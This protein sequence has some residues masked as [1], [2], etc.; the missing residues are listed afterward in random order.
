MTSEARALDYEKVRS[1]L[2][3]AVDD[4]GTAT[5]G[6]LSFIGERLKLFKALAAAG[7]VTIEE[8]AAKTRLNARY[9]REW[10]NAMTAARYVIHDSQTRRYSLPAEHAVVLADE[11]SP[12]FI[13]GFLEMI[14]PAVMQAPKLV[15]AFRNG[16]GVPQSAYPPE[17]FEAIQR[18]SAPWYRHKLTQHWI[19]AMPDVKTK[20]EAGGAM[21]DVG[22]GSGLAAIAIAKAFPEAQVLGYDNHA[23]SIERARANAKAEGVAKRVTF[24]VMDARRLRGP[25][26]DFITTFDVVH[27]SAHPVALLKA[28]RRALKPDGSYLMLEMNCSADVN[29]NVNFIGKLLY[30]VSTLYC[31]TQSLAQRGEGI[32]A[33]MGEPKARELATVAGFAH[34]RRLPIQDP[35]S[36]LYEI[37]A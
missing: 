6:A 13:G 5:L 31:M 27:D 25:K 11:A 19:P 7:P 10:L 20:L 22:C 33:A 32:G 26:F 35:F 15:K 12:F 21:L 36:V 23:G 8:L 30:S 34:F 29:E 1:F 4:V 14:V 18:G 37:R 2:A 3:E 16:K 24:R 17:M 28:I 9:L